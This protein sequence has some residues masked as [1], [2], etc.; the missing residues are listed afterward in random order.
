M[1]IPIEKIISLKHIVVHKDC[2]DGT[3]SAMLLGYCLQYDTL[4]F[5]NYDT[6][7]HRTL[8][9]R[10]NTIF[11]D[12]SPHPEQV[13]D[14]IQAEAIVL[15]HHRTQQ[16]IVAEFGK[17]GVFGDEIANPGVCGATLAF[18]EICKP[19]LMGLYQDKGGCIPIMKHL[20]TLAGIRDTWQ[21]T[22]PQWEE[23]CEQAMALNFWP[24]EYLKDLVPYEW[25]EKLRLGSV[26]R[27]KRLD[28]AKLYGD[29]AFRFVSSKGTRVA[30]FEGAR[31]SSDVADYLNK[32]VDLVVGFSIFLKNE[33]PFM[34]IS[35]RSG[36]TFDCSSFCKAHKGGGHT[37]AAG[38]GVALLPTD[39]Q[40][41]ELV[42][43]ILEVYESTAD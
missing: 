28:K 41:F 40:P 34:L 42:R 16:Q 14:F 21:K 37:K 38:F 20:A 10:P 11:V 15:D 9:V 3:A 19:L 35:T 24:W 12:F 31:M 26:L 27:Q 1:S 36:T 18:R 7:E 13:K 6:E 17:L 43:E 25:D 2:A 22:N 5:V 29:G 33:K 32:E 30:V 8:E 39:L 4:Q 23:A